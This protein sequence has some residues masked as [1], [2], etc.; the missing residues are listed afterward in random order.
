MPSV[1]SPRLRCAALQFAGAALLLGGAAC[2]SGVKTVSARDPS[3]P[4]RLE[5]EIP[6]PGVNGRIDH[7][8]VDLAGKRLFV[9]EVA[10]GS[11]EVIDLRTGKSAARIGG[12]HEPQGIAWIPATGEFVVAC[13]D[14]TVRFFSGRDYRETAAID[15]GSDADDVRTDPRNGH[16]VVGYGDGGLAVIDPATHG[17]VSR[18]TFKGHPEGFAL[19][20]GKAWVND[21]DD[22][23]VLALDLDGGKVLARWPTG[24]HRLNFPMALSADAR[25]LSIAY[26]LPAALARIDAANGTTRAID[27]ACGDSDDLFIV[28]TVTLVVCG[29]GHVDLVEGDR[30][31]ARVETRGGARTG[32][33]VPELGSLF[34][35]LPAR[36]G[37]PAAIWQLRFAGRSRPG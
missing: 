10:N 29:A 20:S 30:T 25:E 11:A 22:G 36:D 19:A 3:S 16:V 33:Y 14:G 5:S 8:A 37:K 18:V 21:P 4:L 9:A 2:A 12:L 26:R 1:A 34:V 27:D 17:V 7:L 23:A 31:E 6:L 15:L 13:G 24:L 32:L 28:G 35:A